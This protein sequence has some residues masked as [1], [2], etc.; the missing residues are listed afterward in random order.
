MADS[1][2]PNNSVHKQHRLLTPDSDNVLAAEPKLQRRL[3]QHAEHIFNL[4]VDRRVRSQ[5]R[6]TAGVLRGHVFPGATRLADPS[7]TPDADQWVVRETRLDVVHIWVD[8]VGQPLELSV[9]CIRQ[10]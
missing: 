8:Q 7:A 9:E 5:R 6:P 1:P 4:A 3:V 10:E 2:K